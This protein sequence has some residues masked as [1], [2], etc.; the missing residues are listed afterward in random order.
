M[1]DLTP[2][3]ERLITEHPFFQDMEGDL[4][5]TMVE[6][7]TLRIY[8][9]GEYIHRHGDAA[10]RFYLIRHGSVAQELPVPDQEPIVIQTLHAG[11]ILGWSWLVPPY[12]W[13]TDVR[14][15]Q[16]TRAVSL[17][18]RCLRGKYENDPLL[19]YELFKRFIP[20]IASRLEAA[21]LQL[22]NIYGEPHRRR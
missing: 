12:H 18:A 3:L 8:A 2:E 21:R 13:T 6:C 10:D 14:A 11:D 5:K 7:A 1:I 19:A 4:R 20:V 15:M 9:A 16:L 17:D 22:I